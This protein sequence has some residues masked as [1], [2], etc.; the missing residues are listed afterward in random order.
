MGPAPTPESTITTGAPRDAPRQ[1]ALKQVELYLGGGGVRA[2][3]RDDGGPAAV[4]VT[5]Q[6]GGDRQGPVEIGT[7]AH[8]CF[9]NFAAATAVDAMVTLPTG[10]V[11]Q[12]RTLSPGLAEGGYWVWSALPDDPLGTYSVL[13][14]QGSRRLET[15]FRVVAP[16]GPR[17]SIV[18]PHTGRPGATF[19]VILAGF[20]PNAVVPV[21]L[22][23]YGPSDGSGSATVIYARS[24]SVQVD[25]RG[26]ATSSFTTRTTDKTGCLVFAG[27]GD[28]DVQCTYSHFH[29]T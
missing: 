16:Q 28:G 13:A 20:G 6:W 17:L 3:P 10:A 29:L 26:R 4:V 12:F 2:C 14:V 18:D 15:S 23:Q 22:Y 21:D 24:F 25:G 11:K 9:E 5:P 7:I 8:I 19:T 1:G 27:T